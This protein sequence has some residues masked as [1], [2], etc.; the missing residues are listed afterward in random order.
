MALAL[1][2]PTSLLGYPTWEWIPRVRFVMEA[3]VWRPGKLDG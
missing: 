3:W 2:L 1:S